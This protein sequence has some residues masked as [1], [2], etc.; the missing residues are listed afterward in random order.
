MKGRFDFGS[1]EIDV[2]TEARPL[3]REDE[4]A[5]PFK[6]LLLG[7]F[8]GRKKG[9]AA[10]VKQARPIRLDRD[11][12]E[13]V[14]ERM[15]AGVEIPMFSGEGSSQIYPVRELDDLH[16]DQLYQNLPLFR[17][18]RELR[19]N[20]Q[21][22]S[23]FPAA[24]EKIQKWAGIDLTAAEAKTPA[25]PDSQLASLTPDQLLRH[26]LGE[27]ISEAGSSSP[28]PS[29]DNWQDFLGKIV[30]PHL[31]PGVDPRQPLLL[32]RLDEAVSALMRRV[33]HDPA[34]QQLEALWRGLFF[35]VSRLETDENLQLWVLDLSRD[36]LFDHLSD[37]DNLPLSRLYGLLIKEA[38]E[39]P[40]ASPWTVVAGLFDVGGD[41]R[42][43]A[44]LGRMA[45]L[46][47][48]GQFPFLAGASTRLLGFDSFAQVPDN[49]MWQAT[50]KLAEAWRELRRIPPSDSLGLVLPRF[51]LRLPY[52]RKT[53]ATERFDFEEMIFPAAHEDFLWIPSA[54]ASVYLMGEA[55]SRNGWQFRPG[56]VQQIDGL[57]FYMQEEG[58]ESKVQPCAEILMTMEMAE[59]ILESG[60]MPLLSFKDRDFIRLAQFQ[61]ISDPW[62]PLR[63]LWNMGE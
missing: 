6:V 36:E 7:N 2:E 28:P 8:S 4:P 52:G 33:L 24:A 21:S 12:F 20:L 11:N 43:I 42:E 35:L 19:R 37:W 34:F 54:V 3:R 63:G 47:A 30:A 38:L 13:E 60:I 15:Q 26:M 5:N 9:I 61:A 14:M 10:S 29:K 23:N 55:F 45:R 53:D 41:V 31:R 48:F 1:A 32:A 51:L 22:P 25:K 57:P 50:G 44:W 39:T 56:E 16:P 40:G 46:A 49:V 17:E 27:E 59:K 58:G 18:L 62:A